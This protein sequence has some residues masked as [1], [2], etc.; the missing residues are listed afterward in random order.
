MTVSLVTKA[1][2]ITSKTYCH[3]GNYDL[4]LVCMHMCACVSVR[5]FV[6]KYVC[7]IVGKRCVLG[8]CQCVMDVVGRGHSL[9][10]V[11]MHVCAPVSVRVLV[12][13]F[14]VRLN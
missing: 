5:A 11:N 6:H 12:C 3:N 14:F 4:I 8:A 9:T 10:L 1:A 2:T 7:I 13:N